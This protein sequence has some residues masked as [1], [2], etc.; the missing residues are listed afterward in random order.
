MATKDLEERGD[1][2]YQVAAA[3]KVASHGDARGKGKKGADKRGSMKS[4]SAG[5]ESR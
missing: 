2:L 1:D 3:T 5:G 4:C